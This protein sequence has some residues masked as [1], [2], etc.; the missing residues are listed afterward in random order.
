MSRTLFWLASHEANLPTI[1]DEYLDTVRGLPMGSEPLY[2]NHDVLRQNDI[3]I[4]R[5]NQ[6]FQDRIFEAGWAFIDRLA[7]SD[8]ADMKSTD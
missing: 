2:W 1:F 8:P 5:I 3:E 7:D 4:E 6:Q